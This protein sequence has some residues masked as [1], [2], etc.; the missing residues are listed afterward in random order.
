MVPLQPQSF[1]GRFKLAGIYD[2]MKFPPYEYREYPKWVK[3]RQGETVLVH[4]ASEEA[5]VLTAEA[6][7]AI[8]DPLVAERDALALEVAALR[9]KF[10]AQESALEELPKALP[11]ELLKAPLKPLSGKKD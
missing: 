10:Q 8:V 4:N 6:H 11:A 9:A 5:G 1:N 2:G 7:Q 3:N